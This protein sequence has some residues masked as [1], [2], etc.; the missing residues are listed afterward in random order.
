MHK[1]AEML[2]EWDGVTYTIGSAF[3]E[4]MRTKFA[5]PGHLSNLIQRRKDLRP[6]EVLQ[7]VIL[8]QFHVL[9]P[10][11]FKVRANLVDALELLHRDVIQRMPL[12]S[13]PDVGR[14]LREEILLQLQPQAGTMVAL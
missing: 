4:G 7:R 9:M 6:V 3:W 8:Q 10:D 2:S 14:Q 11:L 1:V 13:R 5:E 12:C